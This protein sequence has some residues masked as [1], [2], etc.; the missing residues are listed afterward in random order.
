MNPQSLGRLP[1]AQA[2]S[3]TQDPHPATRAPA[4]LLTTDHSQ[5]I[6]CPW[7]GRARVPLVFRGPH[8]QGER[9]HR[10]TLYCRDKAGGASG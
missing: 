5:P 4:P 1:G 7:G 8:P 3:G 2:T 6:T 10:V 9:S